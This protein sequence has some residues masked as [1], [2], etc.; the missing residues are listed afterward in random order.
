MRIVS[1]LLCFCALASDAL[2][3]GHPLGR[4][5][6]GA[7]PLAYR[8]DLTI[9]PER[10]RFTGH[11]EIDVRLAAPTTSLYLHG[12]GL[13]MGSATAVQGSRRIAATYAEVDPLGTAQLTL[14]EPAAAGPVTLI[15]DYDAAFGEG[16]AGL[17]RA[18]VGEDWYVWSQFEA[19]EARAAFPVVRRAG[20]QDA[21]RRP[22]HHRARLDGGG[23]CA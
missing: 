6:A 8:L 18:K 2:A 3:D 1:F 11:V 10:E 19:I 15:F 23:Q 9:V 22:R 5:P 13:S 17:F 20:L 4:L 14:A 16:A 21:V 12:R 7:T